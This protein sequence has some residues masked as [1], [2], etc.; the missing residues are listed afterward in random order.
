VVDTN[1]KTKKAIASTCFGYGVLSGCFF[2]AWYAFVVL[3]H[4]SFPFSLLRNEGILLC[5]AVVHATCFFLAFQDRS[6]TNV[7]WEGILDASPRLQ[8]FCRAL[9]A[10]S[11]W[12]WLTVLVQ[13]MVIPTFRGHNEL[14]ENSLELILSSL[15]FL[16]SVYLA[17]FFLVGKD[18]LFSRRFF[19]LLNPVSSV[20][21]LFHH[22]VPQIH[23]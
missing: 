17:V 2:A 22:A 9:V 14:S 23:D 12:F 16:Q 18:R 1:P 6:T 8:E 19:A 7:R 10:L 15:L 4:Q 5:W 21:R 13:Q 11:L 3:R 20:I